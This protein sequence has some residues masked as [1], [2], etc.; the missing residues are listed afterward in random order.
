M[1]VRRFTAFPNAQFHF[2]LV[3]LIGKRMEE[4]THGGE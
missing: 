4:L 2:S 1:Y 3:T